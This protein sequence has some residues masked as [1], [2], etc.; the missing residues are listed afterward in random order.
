M[1]GLR[2]RPPTTSATVPSPRCQST[3][4]SRN[5]P[6]VSVTE[7]FRA[8][9]LNAAYRAWPGL[10]TNELGLS[11]SWSVS[12]AE[13]DRDASDGAADAIVHVVG[14]RRDAIT[15]AEGDPHARTEVPEQLRLRLG[16]EERFV[17]RELRVRRDR[18]GRRPGPA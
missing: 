15:G 18:G 3:R 4:I 10:S 12:P 2:G 13:L 5:S 7:R 11:L 8:I 9:K 6:S 14:A 1:A 16:D 17:E